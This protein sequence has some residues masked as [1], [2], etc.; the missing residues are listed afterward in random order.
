MRA[1]LPRGG[2]CRAQRCPRDVWHRVVR[3][4]I[5]VAGREQRH[6]V[7]MLQSCGKFD[8]A[9]EPLGGYARSQLG[10][11]QFHDDTT[12]QAR[13][14]GEEHA[15]HAAAT[16]LTLDRV[17]GAE[18]RL[19]WRAEVRSLGHGRRISISRMATVM[20]LSRCEDRKEEI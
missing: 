19:E 17:G 18:R 11:Q 20:Y 10:R 5:H 14:L 4:S 12:A 6:D 13:F 1:P 9:L 8:L 15:R 3:Q 16:E 7:R 2:E